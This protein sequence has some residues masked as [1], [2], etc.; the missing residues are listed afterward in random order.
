MGKMEKRH[1]YTTIAIAAC[2]SLLGILAGYLIWGSIHTARAGV[3]RFETQTGYVQNDVSIASFDDEFFSLSMSG[4]QEIIHEPE[5][6]PTPSH[7]Y[8]VTSQDGY[9]VVRY[10]NS[11]SGEQVHRVT[12]TS[13]S[14]LPLEEQERLAEG[15]Y[16]YNED[17]LF[18]ILEDYGS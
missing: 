11:K 17:A 10:V 7:R 13:V 12:S 8:V 1:R 15:I 14:S 3:T 16:I 5:L 18:R 2:F 4:S 6:L 9:I